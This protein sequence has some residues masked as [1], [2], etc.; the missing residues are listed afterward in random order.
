VNAPHPLGQAAL[1]AIDVRERRRR[2]AAIATRLVS[3]GAD[4]SGVD[5]EMLEKAP[6][7]L[8]LPNATLATF[9]RQVGALLYAG[10]I[11]L[12]I[13]SARIGAARNTLGDGF[14]QALLAQRDLAAF[15]HETGPRKRID[16]ADDVAPLLQVAGA[17]VLLASLA[18]G[19]LRNVVIAAMAPTAPAPIAGE[20]AQSLTGRAQS[21]AA[22]TH[23]PL[24]GA[25]GPAPAKDEQ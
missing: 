20:L 10:E 17:A 9:Q 15:P 25:S 18:P 3:S 5:W 1:A 12:W 2:R 22:A 11:R 24:S 19:A 23:S 21:L 8:A 14:F 16:H 13:D 7:W 4:V 6:T